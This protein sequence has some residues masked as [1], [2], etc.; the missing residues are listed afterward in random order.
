MFKEAMAAVRAALLPT[1]KLDQAGVAFDKLANEL[2]DHDR[3]TVRTESV[4]EFA[5]A[6]PREPELE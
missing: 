5:K 1:E 3:R 2:R 4:L 6:R